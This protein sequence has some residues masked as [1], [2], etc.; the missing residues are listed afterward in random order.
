MLFDQGQK[1]ILIADDSAF[2]RTVLKNILMKAGF[3]TILEAKDL[4][5]N[6]TVNAILVNSTIDS[7][8]R[9]LVR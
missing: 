8:N 9:T 3:N 6:S 4:C 1:K 7:C 5:Q 2:M